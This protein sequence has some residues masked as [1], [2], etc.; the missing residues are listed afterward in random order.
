MIRLIELECPSCGAELKKKGFRTYKCSYC[1]AVYLL[2]VDVMVPLPGKDKKAKAQ[3]TEAAAA[4]PKKVVH[5]VTTKK[6]N[7]G[8][9]VNSGSRVE[10]KPKSR[11]E[12]KSESKSKS[13]DWVRLVMVMSFLCIGIG[14]FA[15][16]VINVNINHSTGGDGK[17]TT[18]PAG[19][20]PAVTS[21]TE[22]KGISP[23]FQEFIRQVYGKE[24]DKVSAKELSELTYFV[25][26]DNK[27]V[28]DYKR[29]DGEL[30]TVTIPDESSLDYEDIR[31]FPEI[32][33]LDWQAYHEKNRAIRYL[34][35]LEDFTCSLS[36]YY[37]LEYIPDPAQLKKINLSFREDGEGIGQMERFENLTDLSLKIYLSSIDKVEEPDLSSIA[38]L[39]KLENIYLDSDEYLMLPFLGEMPSVRSV[40]LHCD[41]LKDISFLEGMPDLESLTLVDCDILS[42][43]NLRYTPKLKVLRIED[44][45]QVDSLEIVTSLVEL[46]ELMLSNHH[47]MLLPDNY[48]ALKNVTRLTMQGFNDITFLEDFPK[49]TFLQLYSCNYS[50]FEKISGLTEL[51]ELRVSGGT[52][53]NSVKPLLKLQKLEK[54]DFWKMETNADTELLFMIPNLKELNLNDTKLVLDLNL[55]EKNESLEVLT[56]ENLSWSAYNTQEGM[57]K[58][59]YENW[60]KLPMNDCIDFVENFPN[61]KHLSVQSNKLE[62]LDFTKSLTKLEYLDITNNYISD[63][64]GLN[65][66]PKLQKVV[67][68]EN[69]LT[70]GYDLDERIEVIDTNVHSDRWP[71]LHYSW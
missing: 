16:L 36:P 22:E 54:V 42:V 67:C 34:S 44:C 11:V 8:A 70:S 10:S 28:V 59:N 9:K 49:L 18:Q 43:E 33:V 48:K 14:I 57:R 51:Q 35:K 46:E 29:N 5:E 45:Y 31:L 32:K 53:L 12:S 41:T 47:G 61:L 65:E 27:Y 1:N 66:L 69:P 71:F 23:Y 15:N 6:K 30:M 7:Q 52:N 40:N 55:V 56:M 63:L 62:N 26:H 25:M 68:G 60:E 19:K 50:N 17:P 58:Y 3:T 39:K 38:K 21:A 37:L 4:Q 13:I 24:P 64:Q 20:N 2:D